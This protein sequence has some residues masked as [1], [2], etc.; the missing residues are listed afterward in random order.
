ESGLPEYNY[1][2]DIDYASGASI[3][4]RT[5]TWQQVGG[6]NELYVPAYCEDADLAFT[7]RKLG[8]P[9]M[10]APFSTLVHHEGVS[11]GTDLATGIKAH[12][13]VNQ[14]RFC[15]RWRRVLEKEQYDN[16][17]ELFVARDRSRSRPH[18]LVIDH[19]VP[20]FDR[21]AGSRTLYEY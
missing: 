3:A 15:K 11:H 7:L 21:D 1:A 2:K 17:R 6:F 20:Q 16:G 19:Y 4:I 12:Q 5:Q 8:L 9:T 18:M 14:N 13:V 10:Y